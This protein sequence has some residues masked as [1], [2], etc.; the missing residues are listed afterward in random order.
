MNKVEYNRKQVREK[1]KNLFKYTLDYIFVHDF[2]GNFLDANEIA[3]NGFSYTRKELK[4]LKFKDVLADKAEVAK[5]IKNMIEI[6]E[7]GRHFH[8]TEYKCKTK[9]GKIVYIETYSIPLKQNGETYAA[10]GFGTPITERK[11]AQKR[12][13]ESEMRYRNLFEESPFGIVILNS[14]GIIIDANLTIE[15]L[16]GYKRDFIIG[17]PFYH[18]SMIIKSE[19]FPMLQERFKDLIKGRTV[20]RIDLE[21]KK[22]DGT[23]VWTQLQGSLLKFHNETH[24]Q[25]LFFNIS[26]RKAAEELIKEQLRKL[27]ELDQTRKD[28]MIRVTHEL[29]TP[30]TLIQTGIEY[31]LESE[32]LKLKDDNKEIINTIERASNR[33]RKLIENLV[34]STKID[35]K[36]LTLTKQKLDFVALI[37][38]TIEDLNYLI[39]KQELNIIT[40]L[41]NKLF[42][43]LDE[44]RIKQVI[45]NLLLNA[46]KNTPP[47]GTIEVILEKK[48]NSINFSVE[49]TG[50]G[51]T[52]EEIKKLFI[53][54]GKIERRGI[55]FEGI[56]IQGSGLGLYISKS[57]VQLHG[58]NIKVVSE[59]R[60]KGSK[61][62]L[63]LPNN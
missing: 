57:I 45:T 58:G 24:V 6:K 62:T 48:G 26:Q 30:L 23:V 16:T 1:Y 51:L 49:D 13:K 34:D 12:L 18:L 7:K 47:K 63:Q 52:S 27:K 46:I 36:K 39:K 29:K 38:E 9:E 11:L 53:P 22:K 14:K 3:L 41:P 17:K 60:N 40:H 54:F 4:D 37:E 42:T 10:L 44:L 31:L 61:F 35:Y 33:L 59:G 15:E 20:H 19:D 25:I 8:R 21:L 43:Y 28:L 50:I 32:T 2:K 56:N 5:A 55:E